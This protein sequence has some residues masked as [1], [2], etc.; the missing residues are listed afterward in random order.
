[1]RPYLEK[2]KSQKRAQV[3]ESLPSKCEALSSN[4]RTAKMAT[5]KDPSIAKKNAPKNQKVEIQK[6]R[7]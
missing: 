7:E 5:T 1:L 4:C 2:K 6:Q 3:V